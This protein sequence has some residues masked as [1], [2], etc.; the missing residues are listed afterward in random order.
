[1]P[2]AAVPG[3]GEVQGLGEG[4]HA[5]FGLDL[6]EVRLALA[7]EGESPAKVVAFKHAL[8]LICAVRSPTR[9]LVE[10]R[11]ALRTSRYTAPSICRYN[12]RSTSFSTTC[13]ILNLSMLTAE[14]LL[15]HGDPR[16][17]I[18]SLLL[19]EVTSR[20][21]F[22]RVQADSLERPFDLNT[23]MKME[24][25]STAKLRTVAHYLELIAGLYDEKPSSASAND[26]ITQWAVR[27]L[28]QEP[29]IG[30]EAF[31]Q[32]A[33]ERS[34]SASPGEVFF[35]GGG[36]H[37]FRNF[38]RG[39]SHRVLTI[40]T[41]IIHS[42]N[43]VFIRLMRDLVRFHTARLSYDANA[44]IDDTNHPLRR[45]LLETI[46]EEESTA[47]LEQVYRDHRGLRE[48]EVIQRLLRERVS[49]R[50][51]AVLFYAW[52]IRSDRQTLAHWLKAHGADVTPAV[53]RKLE[54]AYGNPQQRRCAV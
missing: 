32:R 54:R 21:N 44:L 9:L 11:D 18:Y 47:T 13:T 33:L 22:V 3:Y 16:K 29:S 48:A 15:S 43:L 4:L 37:I 2:L 6:Q 14:R 24:L 46:A 41:A 38:D 39:D 35:T 36:A 53:V 7:A 17:V 45:S 34:Y 12:R 10:D 23:G 19:Y 5:W 27:T 30:L 26:P 51:L 31:L 52:N 8:A 20:G 50:R 25:G 49:P 28:Q 42:T 1:M 40:R